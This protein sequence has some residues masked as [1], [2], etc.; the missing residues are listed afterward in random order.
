MTSPVSI[1]VIASGTQAQ[2][3][4]L[5]ALPSFTGSALYNN[6]TTGATDLTRNGGASWVQVANTAQIPAVSSPS[7]G[8]IFFQGNTTITAMT[9]NQNQ[10]P[11]GGAYQ[12]GPTTADWELSVNNLKYTGIATRTYLVS[13]VF[14]V[15]VFNIGTSPP[16]SGV[17]RISKSGLADLGSG[18]PGTVEL[19][20]GQFESKS[21]QTMST[22]QF[23]NGIMVNT[24]NS[25]DWVCDTLNLTAIALD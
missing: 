16:N 7:Y 1:L 23:L 5:S 25:D 2:R 9:Q 18:I 3:D 6:T 19:T 20:V 14:G 17:F 12:E 8:N 21:I 15:K 13:C 24:Q 11:S 4:T 10:L 22:N